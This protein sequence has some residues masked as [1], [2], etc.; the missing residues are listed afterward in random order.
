MKPQT[1]SRLNTFLDA[2]AFTNVNN[3]GEFR[4]L[5]RDVERAPEVF[6]EPGVD[7]ARPPADGAAATPFPPALGTL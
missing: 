3:L 5:L 2:L 1:P 4:A 6:D 7:D